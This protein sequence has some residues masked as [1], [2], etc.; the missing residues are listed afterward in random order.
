MKLVSPSLNS[1]HMKHDYMICFYHVLSRNSMTIR[2]RLISYE[3]YHI[4]HVE[5]NVT[6]Y[7]RI[8]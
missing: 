6:D 8:M 1:F 3:I 2:L 7:Q 5:N 4:V